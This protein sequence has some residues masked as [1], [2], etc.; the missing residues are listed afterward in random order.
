[1]GE[2][3]RIYYPECR[4]ILQVIF[5]GF[6]SPD[7]DSD[8]MIIPILPKSA[9]VHVNSYKQAD[10][11]ELVF[12]AGDL[13]FDPALIRAGAVEIYVF[14]TAGI[15]DAR[16]VLS[17]RE[18]LTDPDTGG[19]R[20]RADIDTLALELGTPA[21]RDKF[22]LGHKPRIVGLFDDS[23]IELSD[24]GKWVSIKGQDYT[25]HL[26]GEQWKPD[27]DGRARRIPTG[28]RID[29][30][31]RDLLAE[32]D[33]DGHLTVDVRGIE[34]AALPIVGSSEVDGHKRGIPVEQSTSYWDVIYKVV[35]RHGLIVFVD[36]LDVVISRPK[37]ITDKDTSTI[38]RLA[39]GRNLSNLRLSRHLGMEQAPTI[40]VRSYDPRTRKTINVEY[41]DGA[42][43]KSRVFK[44]AIKAP[45]GG[46]SRGKFVDKFK[47]AGTDKP[48]KARKVTTT[49][50][51]R[52]EYQIV[53]VYGITDQNV[54]RRM[55]ENRYHLLGKAERTINA[56]TRD[57]RDL[58]GHDNLDMSAGDAFLIEWDE[59]NREL[60]ANPT[61]T[62]A[63]KIA[64]L[65][66]RGFN[67]EVA[68]EIARRYSILEGVTR[69]VRFKE[70]TIEY[71]VD[72]GISIEME[73][74]DFIVIDGVRPDTGATAPAGADSRRAAMVGRDGKPIGW[75]ME[76]ENAQ[77]RRFQQ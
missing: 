75:S 73:L 60:L 35:E 4:A 17:R 46:L 26:I 34:D 15:D 13:P 8:P 66:D 67:T 51:Q 55:A 50:R 11:W 3:P 12:D 38:R 70:G 44:G 68:G 5:D 24:S 28:K 36:G 72:D 33:P 74:Q 52:D 71:D 53:T 64:H 27:P 42:L 56:T 20:T 54:L 76:F 22:T 16:R 23:D 40:V 62:E 30:L 19:V 1:M 57:L 32:V 6:G 45:K 47:A 29:D 65:V 2:T 49:V 7:D 14:Q 10:S 58:D 59:F 18:P 21:S 9:T 48:K 31:V 25:A 61:V 37:T 39:W 41:P 69:P 43:D 63:A 77:R